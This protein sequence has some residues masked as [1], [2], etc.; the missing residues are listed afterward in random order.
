MRSAPPT[1]TALV[2]S[3]HWFILPSVSLWD[4]SVCW[5]KNLHTPPQNGSWKTEIQQKWKA[6]LSQNVLSQSRLN[7]IWLIN[8][9]HHQ[10]HRKIY[11]KKRREHR[12]W[13]HIKAI[14]TFT[15][16]IA[17]HKLVSH[18]EMQF[19]IHYCHFCSD[20]A[21][22]LSLFHAADILTSGLDSGR[23]CT[24]PGAPWSH[25]SLGWPWSSCRRSVLESH[26]TGG[27]LTGQTRR[28]HRRKQGQR[29]LE[30]KR[31]RWLPEAK[32]RLL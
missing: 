4:F 8:R 12:R 19:E 13:W 30:E 14:K 24:T 23:V 10:L 15:S 29:S 16:L 26:R 21:Y 3:V 31:Q 5:W 1:H 20:R 32:S 18:I 25:L 27:R 17:V 6:V 11:L 22:I 2:H 7:V 28:G 9:S